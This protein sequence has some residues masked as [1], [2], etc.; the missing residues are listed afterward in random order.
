MYDKTAM[1]Y[2]AKWWE[3]F[4]VI[5]LDVPF[6]RLYGP[7]FSLFFGHFFQFFGLSRHP[8]LCKKDTGNVGILSN[9]L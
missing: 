7:P 5:I 3:T 1:E 8:G 6:S 2:L 4:L 9:T